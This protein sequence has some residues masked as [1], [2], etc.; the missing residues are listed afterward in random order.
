MRNHNLLCAASAMVAL[1]VNLSACSMEN[2][3]L[4]GIF[5][6]EERDSSSV[7]PSAEF[8]GDATTLPDADL[9]AHEI[10]PVD[11]KMPQY[12]Q[13][14]DASRLL[15]KFE[16]NVASPELA[17]INI[18][19]SD[20]VD[21]VLRQSGA[22]EHVL[23]LKETGLAFEA[24]ASWTAAEPRANGPLLFI[25]PVA[26]AEGVSLKL[27]SE[28]GVRLETARMGDRLIVSARRN[29]PVKSPVSLRSGSEVKARMNPAMLAP[30][31]V[32]AAPSLPDNTLKV[33]RLTPGSAGDGEG[34]VSILLSAAAEPE[35]K[36][37]ADGEY[38]LRLRN[39]QLDSETLTNIVVPSA[40]AAEHRIY[41]ARPERAGS[42][43]IVHVFNSRGSKLKVNV[44]GTR[45]VLKAEPD[46]V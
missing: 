19:T 20:P 12:A 14:R 33:R 8:L 26:S 2:I 24:A 31:E 18:E 27:V 29:P 41:S 38:T 11:S 10:V 40:G 1:I 9:H 13:A 42:D 44:E 15:R 30:V 17:V 28:P 25:R 4:G 37:I 21:F 36:R 5:E 35:L 23:T 34:S 45:L 6:A 7:T 39:A 46:G 22:G 43:V 32:P 16:V 3:S